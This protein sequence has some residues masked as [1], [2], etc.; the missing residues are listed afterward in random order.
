[1]PQSDSNLP[2]PGG[3]P[4]EGGGLNPA[5]GT[6][7][8]SS[9]EFFEGPLAGGQIA[10]IRYLAMRDLRKALLGRSGDV[11]GFVFGAFTSRGLRIDRFLIETLGPIVDMPAPLGL[12]RVQ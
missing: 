11:L 2:I 9:A 8:Y 10:L 4:L 5:D 12:F 7:E 3:V 1:M 6:A